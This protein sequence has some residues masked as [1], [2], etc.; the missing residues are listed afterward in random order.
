MLDEIL[1]WDREVLIY[2]NRLGAEPYDGFWAVITIF[3]VWT[4]LF[5]LFVYLFFAQ[6]PKKR[7][8][9]MIGTVILTGLLVSAMTELTKELV[10]RIRLNNQEDLHTLIRILKM[11][12]SYSFFSGHAAGSFSIVTTVFL[13]LRRKIKW[14]WLIFLWPLI[15]SM[16]R[17]YVGVHYPLDILTGSLVGTGI[18]FFVV[19]MYNRSILPCLMSDRP[20]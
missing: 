15:V 10:A 13:F 5:L 7:A 8:Y 3:G 4:P 18:A 1:Q 20:G 9:A 17:I 12:K 16:S 6:F 19:R 14:G 11:P 2:L